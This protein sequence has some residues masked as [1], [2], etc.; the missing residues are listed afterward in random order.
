M[1]IYD[2]ILYVVYRDT[3]SI[4]IQAYQITRDLLKAGTTWLIAKTMTM[5]RGTVI[6][7]KE[8]L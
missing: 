8:S 2:K 5:A 7:T 6:T 4:L 3:Y 1:Y